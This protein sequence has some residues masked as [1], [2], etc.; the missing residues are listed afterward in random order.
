MWLHYYIENK[1]GI[2]IIDSI[3]YCRTEN[4]LEKDKNKKMWFSFF[5]F[6]FFFLEWASGQG[7]GWGTGI[8]GRKTGIEGVGNGGIGGGG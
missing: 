5:F 7:G 3:Q 1:I 8:R 6:F 4:A 2:S